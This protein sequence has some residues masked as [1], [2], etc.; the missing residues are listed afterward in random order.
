[1]IFGRAAQQPLYRIL[2]PLGGTKADAVALRL[3]CDTAKRQKGRVQA[4]YVIEVLRALPLDAELPPELQKGEE[5]LRQAE[6]VAGE[7]QVE[8]D[9]ELLQARE[10]GPA[11]VDE[12]CERG[13]QLIVMGLPYKRRFG[14]FSMGRTV[15]YVLKNAPCQ[16]W[17]CREPPET[18]A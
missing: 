3:A 1:M 14:D 16:V 10:A 6:A 12:A 4:V 15:P 11:V 13:A 2:V 17:V 5:V 18:E 9:T 7:A 8:I